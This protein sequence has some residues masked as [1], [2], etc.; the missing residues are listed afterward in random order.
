M[1][2]PNVEAAVAMKEAGAWTVPP[3]PVSAHLAPAVEAVSRIYRA[4]RIVEAQPMLAINFL[5]D[6]PAEEW[7][8]H[9]A[10]LHEQAGALRRID[11]VPNH[12]LWANLTLTCERGILRGDLI[13]TGEQTPRI[14]SL[15]LEVAK[16]G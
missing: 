13:L 10:Q 4:A 16:D 9:L 5:L 7:D 8:R 11:A 6:R 3:Q 2:E 15:T 12:P 1:N 14:Q